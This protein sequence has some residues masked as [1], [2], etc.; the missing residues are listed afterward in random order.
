MKKYICSIRRGCGTTPLT[1]EVTTTSALKCANVLGHAGPDEVVLVYGPR[2]LIS[3]VRWD[4]QARKYVRTYEIGSLTDL[5]PGTQ[6]A[7]VVTDQ[8][9]AVECLQGWGQRE[10]NT[11][12]R[13]MRTIW[14]VV[15]EFHAAD[16][17]AR[18]AEREAHPA[19]ED[20]TCYSAFIDHHLVEI[21]IPDS[22]KEVTA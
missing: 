19:D 6:R 13:P 9:A 10:L 21:F 12:S 7:I 15:E 14:A 3:A 17:C 18:L 20:V 1:Y 22:W 8:Y 5:L 2:G 4:P 11:L 16:L